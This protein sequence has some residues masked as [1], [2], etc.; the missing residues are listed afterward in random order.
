MGSFLLE[1]CQVLAEVVTFEED[2]RVV[3]K[4]EIEEGDVPR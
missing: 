2:G 4:V 3:V 1:T